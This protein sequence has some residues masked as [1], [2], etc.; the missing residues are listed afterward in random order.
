MLYQCHYDEYD[1]G[2]G[3]SLL[4]FVGLSTLETIAKSQ[5]HETVP[6][7]LQ[8]NIDYVSY[9]VALKLRRV[10]RNPGILDVVEVVMKYSALDFLP[11]LKEIVENV[12]SRSNANWRS[13][14]SLPFLKVFYTFLVCVRR[15]TS[16]EAKDLEES[17]DSK[18][19]GT[20]DPVQMA[21]KNAVD[22]Y[23]AKK[24]SRVFEDNEAESSNEENILEDKNGDLLKGLFILY[25]THIYILC[26]YIF[27]D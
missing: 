14:T 2:S 24:S 5:G 12:L 8:E 3:Q 11:C 21:I 9:Q 23:E 4:R 1:S 15:L 10:E 17:R 20:E 6:G 27:L 22:Y 19:K 26:V 18:D 13:C 16:E 7:L 25:Y